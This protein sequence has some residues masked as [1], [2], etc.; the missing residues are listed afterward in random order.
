MTRTFHRWSIVPPRPTDRPKPRILCCADFGN[1]EIAEDVLTLGDRFG[2]AVTLFGTFKSNPMS[3]RILRSIT[4]AY[5]ANGHRYGGEAREET[6]QHLAERSVGWI[7]DQSA[8]SRLAHLLAGSNLPRVLFA[9]FDPD[10]ATSDEC[11]DVVARN[12]G[13]LSQW[14]QE[15]PRV[16]VP[17]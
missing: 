3:V 8:S 2:V 1:G 12:R 15:L 4:L 10:G 11:L 13:E 9:P 16:T 14:M 7:V 5:E 17:A 6:I